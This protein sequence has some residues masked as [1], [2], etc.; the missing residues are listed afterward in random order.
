MW[1]VNQIQLFHKYVHVAQMWFNLRY[2][3][4]Y[5][6]NLPKEKPSVWKPGREMLHQW[7]LFLPTATLKAMNL[8]FAAVLDPEGIIHWKEVK[9]W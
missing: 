2:L 3:A 7:E 4:E 6:L 5:C 8:R 9:R 1:D